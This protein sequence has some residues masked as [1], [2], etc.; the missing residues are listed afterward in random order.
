M[1]IPLYANLSDDFDRHDGS[2][3]P[4]V[5]STGSAL[6]YE[7][8][9]NIRAFHTTNLT[10]PWTA[11]DNAWW[12][13]YRY[14][15]FGAPQI[16]NQR[17]IVN[18]VSRGRTQAEMD[19]FIESNLDALNQFTIENV[20][21]S[22]GNEEWPATDPN[23]TVG[24]DSA[25]RWS[26]TIRVA[27][28]N[29]VLKTVNSYYIDDLLTD[30][31]DSDYQI[32]FVLRAFPSQADAAHLDLV[33]SSVEF[34]SDVTFPGGT[35]DTLRFVDTTNNIN[36]TGGTFDTVVRWP[37]ASLVKV[38]RHNVR[39]IRL[40]LLATGGNF[41]FIAQ[42]LRIVPNN[43][44]PRIINVDT[45][46]GTLARMVPKA[47]G[48]ESASLFGDMYLKQT[49]PKNLTMYTQFNSGHLPA[50]GTDDNTFRQY[51]RYN[52]STGDRIEVRIVSRS[53]QTRLFI[54]QKIGGVTTTLASTGTNTNI[55][56]AETDYYLVTT[57]NGT[58]VTATVYAS[59]G[60][61]LG[62]AVGTLTGTGTTTLT[63]RGYVGLSFEPY[64]YDFVLRYFGTNTADFGTF[65]T[66]N[67]ISRTPVSGATLYPRTSPSY[68]LLGD[69]TFEAFADA[70]LSVSSD[71]NTFTVTRDG[72][73]NQ[74]G[75][76]YN[77][78]RWIG[79]T[80]Q[81]VVKGKLFP[82]TAVHGTYRLGLLDENDQAAW[83]YNFPSLLANQW[84]EFAVPLPT[85]FN[86]VQYF[87]H[88][89]QFGNYADTFRVRDLELS[90]ASIA[91]EGTADAGTHW[92][93]FLTALDD[94]WSAIKFGTVGKSLALRATAKSDKAY[95]NGYNLV[96]RY[97]P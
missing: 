2:L 36:G 63:A 75:V 16:G 18:V 21:V 88:I 64:Y 22:S 5:D 54:D 13:G 89:Q 76:R 19:T 52:V 27:L 92:Q 57:L 71:G 84:N 34:S 31:T 42:A 43:W 61:A 55:L 37:L 72:V 91:W 70:D 80:S 93:P 32:E 46:R 47:G 59:N 6:P 15:T 1:G 53:T 50:T 44:T 45:K 58:S 48:T 38:D 41:T 17:S 11:N 25:Y 14:P 60:L 81:V 79:D 26:N 96:P 29:G 97:I 51:Y 90:H 20:G 78:S 74:G 3:S 62:V 73:S 35:T 28:T 65:I 10:V 82:V 49:R 66:T 95:I 56:T 83:I 77:V 4:Y 94:R 85:G 24:K 67:F 23:V 9:Y 30:F 7:K 39:A 86:P 69:G 33:N 8:H 40:N 87:F 68:N 12:A